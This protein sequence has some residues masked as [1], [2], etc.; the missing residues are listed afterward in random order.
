[1]GY[2]GDSPQKP[3]YGHRHPKHIQHRDQDGNLY[4]CTPGRRQH[5]KNL[6]SLLFVKSNQV[7]AGYRLRGEAFRSFSPGKP[8]LGHHDF[9]KN[10]S[11]I[12]YLFITL[13]SDIGK[14]YK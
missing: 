2:E 12:H 14:T 9:L 7:L 8:K 13:P 10:H 1:V 3:C 6:H 5:G 4:R 11:P